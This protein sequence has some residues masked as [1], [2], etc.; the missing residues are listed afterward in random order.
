MASS[1]PHNAFISNKFPDEI[2]DPFGKKFGEV[3]VK[4]GKAFLTNENQIPRDQVDFV[5]TQDNCL[6]IGRKHTTL[7][8]RGDVLA[9]GRLTFKNG[10]I[11]RIT[12]ESGHFRPT[13][14]EGR[15]YPELFQSLGFDLTGAKFELCEF[16]LNSNGEVVNK[17][18][19]VDEYLL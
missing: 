19:A 5:I 14:E 17:S 8:D 15:R 3:Q 11:R 7:S 9:A 13:V 1:N 16:T 6:V 10:I 12:N 4:G 2:L 18:L